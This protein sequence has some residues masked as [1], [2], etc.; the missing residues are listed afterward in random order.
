LQGPRLYGPCK[1]GSYWPNRLGLFDMHGN[2]QEWCNDWYGEDYY[3]SSPS[4]D[5]P[6]PESGRGRV[7]RG[8]SW[9]FPGR[10][11]RA[12]SRGRSYYRTGPSYRTDYEYRGGLPPSGRIYYLG[13]RAAAVPHE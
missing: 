6:G 10:E 4:A 2:I 13:F 8:G 12:A 11:C 9:H 7:F 5:P 1:V 3:K